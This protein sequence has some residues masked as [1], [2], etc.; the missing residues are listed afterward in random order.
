M[1]EEQYWDRDCLLVKYYRDAEEIRKERLNQE[2][3]LQ[4][5]YVYDALLR[6]SPILRP[7][8]KKGT[9]PKPYTEEPYPITQKTADDAKR[10]REEAKSK[11]G[12][13][14]MQTYMAKANKYFEERK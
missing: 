11:K 2:L 14:Y 9:K 10:R 12:M 8:G 1:T 3:W 4:G 5:M 7:F 6:A 13:L